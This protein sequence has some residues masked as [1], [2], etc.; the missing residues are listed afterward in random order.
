MAKKP[1]QVIRASEL[2]EYAY[3]ARAW[4]LGRVLGYRSANLERMAAGEAA[5]VR[6][7]QKV[8]SSGRLRRWAYVLLVLALL[9]GTL[10]LV[11]ALRS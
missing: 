9:A 10:F 4:W 6:H 1:G 2:G 7:G 5:H 11:L 3:C 8:V